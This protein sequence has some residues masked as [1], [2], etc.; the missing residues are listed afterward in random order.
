MEAKSRWVV[1][2]TSKSNC[3]VPLCFGSFRLVFSG[4][5]IS[6]S[7]SSFRLFITSQTRQTLPLTS[8]PHDLFSLYKG[9]EFDQR[10]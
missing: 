1:H 2:M 10:S 6:I 9:M 7:S 5:Q 3:D 4:N 8:T